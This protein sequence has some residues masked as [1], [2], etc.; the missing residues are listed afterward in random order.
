MKKKPI[1][2]IIPS[3]YKDIK[4]P[5]NNYIKF[6]NNY[7]EMIN[8]SGGIPLGI[9]FPNGEFNTKLLKIC[10]GFLIP[11]GSSI[12]S[13]QINTIHYAIM[14]KKPVLGI[15]LGMQ[16]IGAYVYIKDKYKNI[17]YQKIENIFNNKIENEFLEKI[18]NH[19]KVN[20]FNLENINNSKHIVVLNKN[21]K[22]YNIYKKS[23]LNIPSIHNYKVKDNII[24]NS[25]YFKI[26]GKSLD[27]VV[28][29]I[30]N[31]DNKNFIIG[32]QFH[33][34]LEKENIVLFRKLIKWASFLQ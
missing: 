2:G 30:E 27:N 29:V 19:N 17:S 14:N 10:D 28:E 24:N 8:K 31:I 13:Y 6:V 34:E 26:T 16:V 5:F 7:F 23:K 9:L 1:I 12:N 4:N 32:V 18:T 25:K 15:C 21:S 11:G 20:P 3:N 33:P 22:I